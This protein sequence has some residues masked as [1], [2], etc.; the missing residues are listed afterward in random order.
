MT[1][2]LL[3]THEWVV[4]EG[5]FFTRVTIISREELQSGYFASVKSAMSVF[6]LSILDHPRESVR[7]TMMTSK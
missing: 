7:I 1:S 6:T 2:E 5:R 4:I 3:A